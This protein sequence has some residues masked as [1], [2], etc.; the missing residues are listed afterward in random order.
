MKSLL[1]ALAV[2]SYLMSVGGQGVDDTIKINSPA[3]GRKSVAVQATRRPN[4]PGRPNAPRTRSESRRLGRS[5]SASLA[6]DR[7]DWSWH[8]A[9]LS[10]D[11]EIMSGSLIN[12]Q[13]ILTRAHLASLV[14][15][16]LLVYVLCLISQI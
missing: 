16:L 1:L 10:S 4:T 2:C 3:C 5:M 14:H 7:T 12:S 11:M 15:I 13:W 6:G 8:A 9:L